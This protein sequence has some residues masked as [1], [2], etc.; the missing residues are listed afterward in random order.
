MSRFGPNSEL[1]DNA[2]AVAETATVYGKAFITTFLE[3]MCA[4]F[5]AASTGT[6]TVAVWLEQSD[7]IPDTEEVADTNFVVNENASAIISL[8]N[9]LRHNI[10][11]APLPLRYSRFKYIGSGSNH[12]STTVT[13]FISK[14]ED[15]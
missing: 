13:S 14:V 8:A 12:S 3:A 10:A 9:E 15:Q 7:Q 5:V 11:I 1:I 2:K 4:I 6:V